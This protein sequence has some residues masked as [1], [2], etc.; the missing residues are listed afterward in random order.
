[1]MEEVVGKHGTA[2]MAAI[3]GYRVAG[4]TGTAFRYDDKKGR[5]DGYVASFIGLAPA[6]DPKLVVAVISQNPKA[7]HF[8]GVTGGPVFKEVMSAALQM[9]KVPPSGTK[10]P[11]LPL[12]APGSTKGGPWNWD[13]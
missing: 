3:D 6:D 4:K 10:A 5:Y 8:G 1:M 12:H 13:N 2:P 7:E 11:E 9:M